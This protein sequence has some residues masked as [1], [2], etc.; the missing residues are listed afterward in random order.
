MRAPRPGCRRRAIAL[1]V[2]AVAALAGCSRPTPPPLLLVTLD[3][4]RYDRFGFSGD[5][6][7]RT[8]VIDALAARGT[9]FRRAYA[10]TP[11]T[12]PS[13]TTIL[14]GV[15]PRVHGVHD[16]GRYR[17]PDEL[18]TLAERLSAA[19]YE[20]AAFVGA[21]VLDPR[22]NLDQGFATY[23]AQTHADDNPLSFRVPERPAAEVTDDALAWLEAREP[24]DAPFFLWVHYYDPHQPLAAPPPFDAMSDGYAAEIAYADAQLGRL[25][26]AVDAE[27][28]GRAL[29]VFTSDH[30]ESLGEHGEASHGLLT[31]DSTLHVPLVLS[32][33]GVP[34]GAT[35]D[36]LAR[37]EDLV[38]TVLAALGLPRASE[39]PGRDLLRARNDDAVIGYFESRGPAVSLGWAEIDGVRTARW[40][41]IARPDPPELYDVVEDPAEQ[42]DRA[43]ERPEVMAALRAS[44]AALTGGTPASAAR[45]RTLSVEERGRLAALGYVDAPQRYAP[46]RRPDP[47]AL[48]TVHAWVE[49]A[50]GLAAAGRYTEAVEALEVLAQSEPVRA[51]VLRSLAPVYAQLGRLDDAI[52]AYRDYVELTGSAEGRVTLAAVLLSRGSPQEALDALDPLPPEPG[53]EL[54]RARALGRL[55]RT[56][57]A[58]ARIDAAFPD[59]AQR[60]ERLREQGLLLLDAAPLAEGDAPLRALLAGAPDDPVLRSQ[61]GYYLA[62]WGEASQRDEALGLLRDA[63]QRVPQDADLLSRLGW[64]AF[65]RGRPEEAVS[66]LE[67]AVEI[68]PARFTDRARLGFALLAVGERPRAVE[69]LNRAVAENPGAEWAGRARA[70]LEGSEAGS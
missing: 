35:R 14:T 17:V 62:V 59:P 68:D 13:H 38:P 6:E 22:F 41:L 55:G 45:A 40:K 15:D 26:A 39:L 2:A 52:R 36:A 1:S 16:N 60:V 66:A 5:P 27:S 54:L 51:L 56:A 23:H 33:P 20:A 7:A 28:S 69:Q 49:R 37:H 50:R 47:R 57:E 34:V 4:A 32:G 25:L 19:G 70:V 58:Q 8:P 44:Y 12:L 61:L 65:K 42:H 63:A 21:F 67:A 3:T 24:G 48:A 29:V 11:L 18:Q 64:G 10:G 30:G 9:V 53:T 43:L 46:G 31:Y